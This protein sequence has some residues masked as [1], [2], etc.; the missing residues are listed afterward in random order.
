MLPGFR[1]VCA[2]VVMSVSLVI[3]GLGAAALLQASHQQFASL[4]SLRSLPGAGFGRQSSPMP[5][6]AMLRLDPPAQAAA[7]L[8]DTSHLA[9]ASAPPVQEQNLVAPPVEVPEPAALAP[10]ATAAPGSTYDVEPE[11]LAIPE[12]PKPDEWAEL[13]V[14]AMPAPATVVLE[15]AAA[16]IVPPPAEPI[17]SIPSDA[18]IAA[19]PETPQDDGTR[20]SSVATA[21]SE[22]VAPALTGETEVAEAAHPSALVAALGDAPVALQAVPMPAPKPV[23][24]AQVTSRRVITKRIVKRRKPP[25]RPRVVRQAPQPPANPFGSPFGAP[26]GS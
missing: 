17:P 24:R 2:A 21:P 15:Q 23:M 9:R 4:P 3:F 20:K 26:F 8:Q 6:L 13:A 1:L 14:P 10:G 22:P 16:A 5:T 25:P 18:I 7:A 19:S 11:P 12:P